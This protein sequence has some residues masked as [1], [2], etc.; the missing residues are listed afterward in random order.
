MAGEASTTRPRP[1]TVGPAPL[2][3]P[4]PAFAG[5]GGKPLPAARFSRKVL[6]PHAL[7]PG[8]RPRYMASSFFIEVSRRGSMSREQAI[9]SQLDASAVRGDRPEKAQ[10]VLQEVPRLAL[11]L[12]SLEEELT[13][14]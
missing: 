6:E 8:T 2:P 10:A 14:A 12:A 5:R 11:E 1:P 7:T 4:L 13:R 9:L 3:D